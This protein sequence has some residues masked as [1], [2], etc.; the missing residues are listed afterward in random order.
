M[1]PYS[2]TVPRGMRPGAT[3]F[4]RFLRGTLPPARRASARPIAMACLRLFT[5]LP[6]RP[7]R[8]VPCLRSCIAFLTFCEAFFPYLA[9]SDSYLECALVRTACIAERCRAAA[10]RCAAL[11]CACRLSAVG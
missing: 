7:L 6:E 4:L 2:T 3:Y 8:S 1:L 10:L 11:A 9:M 5:F